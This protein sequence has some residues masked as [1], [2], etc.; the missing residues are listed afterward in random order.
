MMPLPYDTPEAAELDAKVIRLRSQGLTFR[1]IAD[2]LGYVAQSY[3]Y[4]CYQRAKRRIVA[5]AVEE[6]RANQLAEIETER[7][8]L[9]DI[10]HAEHPL[11][12]NGRR[13]DDLIDD[14][15]V[16]AALDRRAKLRAQEQDL[17][18]LKAAVKVDAVVEH[19]TPADIE[20]R[21]LV[22]RYRARNDAVR[23]AL[24]EQA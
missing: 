9:D 20:L 24:R 3:M 2:E 8:L 15:P 23:E 14:G 22:Q 12:S 16:L 1:E 10:I 19:V 17:L 11:V 4:R 5:P 18:G 6:Y 21:E 13:F 7:E